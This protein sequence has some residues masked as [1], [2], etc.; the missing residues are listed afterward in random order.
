MLQGD[1]LPSALGVGGQSYPELVLMGGIRYPVTWWNV[2]GASKLAKTPL[3]S[4]YSQ[5]VVFG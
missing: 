3:L 4:K 1:F 5:G 2:R